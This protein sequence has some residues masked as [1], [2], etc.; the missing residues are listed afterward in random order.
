MKLNEEEEGEGISRPGCR[1]KYWANEDRS[2]GIGCRREV[3]VMDSM[4]FVD[5]SAMDGA[6]YVKN[7]VTDAEESIKDEETDSFE[8]R[9][10]RGVNDWM[11]PTKRR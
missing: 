7:N 2:D 1:S 6:R 11:C 3:T 9:S 4:K 5:K 8:T 10:E